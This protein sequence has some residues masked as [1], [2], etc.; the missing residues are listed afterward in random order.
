MLPLVFYGELL[1]VFEMREKF[2]PGVDE[3]P[4][5]RDLKSI[6]LIIYELPRAWCGAVVYLSQAKGQPMRVPFAASWRPPF[7]GIERAI[8]AC[9]RL[10]FSGQGAYRLFSRSEPAVE[11]VFKHVGGDRLAQVIVHP[12][13]EALPAV[14]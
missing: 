13:G 7:S 6:Q 11:H 14:C 9:R 1:Q 2:R 4:P 10:G 12:C 8:N 3:R 5:D